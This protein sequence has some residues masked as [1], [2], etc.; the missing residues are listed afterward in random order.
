M[1][2]AVVMAGGGKAETLTL[3]E[4]V[5]NKAFINL[6]GK[7]LLG[8]ILD[9]LQ[10]APSIDKIVVVGPIH[11][12]KPMQQSGFN[13]T[14]VPESGGMLDN[15]A[16]GLGEVQTDS[17]CLVVS[18]DIPLL[19]ADV[20]EEFIKLCAPHDSDFYY[21]ILTREDCLRQ[22]PN[23][24]RTY[25]RLKEG[26]VTGGNIGLLNPDWFTTNRSRLEMFIASRKKPLKLMRILPLSLIV[27]YLMK[28]LS[29]VDLETF[30]S[31]L[32]QLEARAIPCK[33]VE[34]GMD[35]DKASDL[36]II[37]NTMSTN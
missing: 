34:I 27:K 8:Y 17:L 33:R 35:I 15:L 25:V 10:K 6:Q 2:D 29:L 16:A 36:E 14:V 3:Q 21:P 13:F 31:A 19:T 9:G 11:L 26:Y 7:P 32:L 20:I 5:S 24:E 12:L 4:E 37:R 22:F 23:T 28:T 30:L 1:F 18:A